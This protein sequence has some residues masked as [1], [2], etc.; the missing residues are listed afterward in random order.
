MAPTPGVAVAL[1]C[2]AVAFVWINWSSYGTFYS[3]W[4]MADYQHGPLVPVFSLFLLWW[5]RDMLL[6]FAGRGSWWGLAFLAL[7]A[8]MRVAAVYFNFGSLPEMSMLPFFAGLALFV[9]GWQAFRWA[10]PAIVFLLFM[11]PLPGDVQSALSFQLQAICHAFERL[12][13]PDAGD[14]VCCDWERDSIDRQAAGS[15]AS[16]QRL[17]NDDDVLRALHRRGVLSQKAAMGETLHYRQRHSDRDPRQRGADRGDGGLPRSC[18]ALAVAGRFGECGEDHS[19]HRGLGHR[20]AL[21]DVV[22]LDRVDVIVEAADSAGVGAAAD[23]GHDAAG[24]GA[25]G[26]RAKRPP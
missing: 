10:W 20:D 11:L 26:R 16:V 18:P 1:V 4:S 9:G 7:W 19:R 12:Y 2:L 15:G 17:A 22:A 25:V 24:A 23:D 8:W 3:A 5:R 6:P 14:S 13:H 21:R